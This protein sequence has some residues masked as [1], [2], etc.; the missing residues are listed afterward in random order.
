MHTMIFLAAVAFCVGAEPAPQPSLAWKVDPA[1]PVI[2]PGFNGNLDARRACAAHVV[3]V[4]G[5]YRM[6]YW[7]GD[8]DGYN[9]ICVAESEPDSPT[10]WKPR[11]SVLERQPDTDYNVK[12]PG[13]PF[14]LPRDDG[15]W[16]MYVTGWGQP[17]PGGG[18]PNRTCLALSHDRGRTWKYADENPVIPL[19]MPYDKEATGSVWVIRRGNQFCMYY[20]AIGEYYPRPPGVK[21]GHGERIPAIGIAYAVSDDGIRWTKPYRHWLVSPRRFQAEPY[22]Y[23]CSKP[24]IVEENGR[25]RMWVNTFGTAYRIRSLTSG[26]GIFWKW[27]DSPG[28]PGDGELGVGPTGSWDDLQRSYICALKSGGKYHAW[29]TGNRFGATGIGHATADIPTG[30]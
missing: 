15:P 17:K 6:Y 18:I 25:Y 27:V 30:R 13:F 29:F 5:A 19:D 28:A 8:A 14:V 23:I 10:G 22:E 12:G 9:R 26:D 7:G 24:C 20:T 3:E 11:G 2:K 16:L 4:G 21:T 1:Q